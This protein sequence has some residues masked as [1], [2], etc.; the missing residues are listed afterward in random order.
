MYNR[1]VVSSTYSINYAFCVPPSVTI[2][3]PFSLLTQNAFLCIKGKRSRDFNRSENDTV[4][5][6][7]RFFLP[8]AKFDGF[9]LVRTRRHA[10]KAEALLEIPEPRREKSEYQRKK[11]T[12]E[13]KNICQSQASQISASEQNFPQKMFHFISF[14]YCNKNLNILLY[15]VYSLHY[16]FIFL[17][18]V[19]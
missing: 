4:W 1:F 9:G 17:T 3:K 12:L 15:I 6:N 7:F 19:I 16:F 8:A 14:S 11:S 2:I 13:P 18:G 5:D 10:K